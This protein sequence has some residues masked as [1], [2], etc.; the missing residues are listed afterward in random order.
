MDKEKLTRTFILSVALVIFLFSIYIVVYYASKPHYFYTVKDF[1]GLKLSEYNFSNGVKE[2]V[3][4]CNNSIDRNKHNGTILEIKLYFVKHCYMYNLPEDDPYIKGHNKYMYYVVTH[5]Y[6]F[7]LLYF[8]IF[9][10]DEL[11]KWYFNK[12]SYLKD[13]IH[14]FKH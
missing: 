14:F 12:A 7:I 6:L 5:E 2:P 8:I 3:L 10:L 9:L 13:L 11:Y 4:D 1:E